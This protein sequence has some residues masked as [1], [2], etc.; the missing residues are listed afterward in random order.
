MH[1]TV[2]VFKFFQRAR[3][4]LCDHHGNVICRP[5]WKNSMTHD[6][7]LNPCSEPICSCLHGECRGGLISENI[8]YWVPSRDSNIVPL[9]WEKK[10]SFSLC[11]GTMLEQKF[12][13]VSGQN[14]YLIGQKVVIFLTFPACF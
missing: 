14:H 5:G 11:P 6:D 9:S 12:Q 4:Y 3:S 7:K 13:D 10:E 8:F 2:N 1:G